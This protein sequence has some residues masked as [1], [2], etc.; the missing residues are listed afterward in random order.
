LGVSQS[1]A[2]ASLMWPSWAMSIEKCPR[3]LTAAG[4]PACR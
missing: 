1:V 3:R 2:A 4:P